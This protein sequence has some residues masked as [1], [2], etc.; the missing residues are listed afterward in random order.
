MALNMLHCADVPLSNYSLTG[1][2]Q[3]LTDGPMVNSK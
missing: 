1:N 3:K 2:I